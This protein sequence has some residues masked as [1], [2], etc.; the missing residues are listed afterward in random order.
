[1]TLSPDDF[2]PKVG[3]AEPRVGKNWQRAKFLQA[4]HRHCSQSKC[5]V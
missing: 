4:L 3:S 5:D 1:M 2:E